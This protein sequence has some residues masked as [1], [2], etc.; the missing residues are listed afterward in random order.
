MLRFTH[1][2]SLCQQ[3]TSMIIG[4]SWESDKIYSEEEF[5]RKPKDNRETKARTLEE[6]DVFSRYSYSKHEV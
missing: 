2:L 3:N 1:T 4:S 6:C 5:L